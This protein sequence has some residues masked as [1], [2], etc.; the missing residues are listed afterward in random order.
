MEREQPENPELEQAVEEAEQD[1]E[2]TNQVSR[3][4]A[5][6]VDDP[7]VDPQDGWQM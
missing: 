4:E 7:D 2:G 3:R 5:E 1:L 6:Q